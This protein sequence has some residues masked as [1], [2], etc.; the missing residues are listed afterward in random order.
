MAMVQAACCWVALAKSR[1]V[2]GAVECHDLLALVCG[3][4]AADGLRL[5]LGPVAFAVRAPTARSW[6]LGR[7]VFFFGTMA[8][9]LCLLLVRRQDLA[10]CSIPRH[11]RHPPPTWSTNGR[12]FERNTRLIALQPALLANRVLWIGLRSWLARADRGPFPLAQHASAPAGQRALCPSRNRSDLPPRRPGR[13][14]PKPPHRFGRRCAGLASDAP[15]RGAWIPPHCRSW[16]GLGPWSSSPFFQC[17]DLR[18]SPIGR[19]ADA[20]HE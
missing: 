15:G 3:D 18:N 16:L 11:D 7:V 19:A 12:C 4:R 6:L 10:R 20:A 14:V 5:P 2:A 8:R 17:F 1:G 9:R 13:F